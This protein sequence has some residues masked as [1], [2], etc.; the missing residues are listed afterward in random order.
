[1]R[2]FAALLLL[3]SLLAVAPAPLSAQSRAR[4]VGTPTAADA[5]PPS[6]GAAPTPLP[7]QS[8]APTRP[9]AG[10]QAEAPEEVGEDDVVTVNTALVTIPVTVLDRDGR[11]I[12]GLRQED[13]RIFEDGVE[14]QVAYFGT[15]EQP[16]T[17]ALVLD[18]SNSTRF[19]IDEIQDAALAFIDQLRPE[20]RVLVVS[21]DSDVRTLTPP[22]S[23]RARL[24]EAVRRTRNGGGT[25]LYDAVDYVVKQHLANVSG[26]KAIVLFTDGVDT[27]SRRASYQSTLADAEEL[28]ALIYPVQYDTFDT[29][30][31]R[32][33]G[34]GTWPPR[35]GGGGILGDILGSIIIGGKGGGGGGGGAGSSRDEYRRAGEYLRNLAWMTGGRHQDASDLRNLERAFTSIAEEL[36]RQYTL[37]Y[38]PSRQAAAASR[39]QLKVRVKRPN[40]V[41]RARDSYVYKPGA[42]APATDTA[43]DGAPQ[44]PELRRRQFQDAGP[45]TL[46]E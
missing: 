39:R 42:A 26:R 28:D 46:K 38:H 25:R 4:R 40:L 2:N 17:V 7:R 1:M 44:R 12:S 45:A 20:D 5:P 29:Q 13:F 34:G 3:L 30:Q 27:E 32:G 33:G 18:T 23:D 22:T 43:R 21:F 10:A 31:S 8:P 35:S 37:G 16:F 19:K 9:P 41:V 11:F 24:R 15:V 14:Q 36:R 6:P